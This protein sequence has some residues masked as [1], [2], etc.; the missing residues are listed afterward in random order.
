M[1]EWV[2]DIRFPLMTGKEKEFILPSRDVG[3]YNQ[4][5]INDYV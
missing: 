3:I 5:Q 4:I 1:K 2:S